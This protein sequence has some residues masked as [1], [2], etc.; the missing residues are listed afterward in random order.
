VGSRKGGDGQQQPAI[1]D[2]PAALVKKYRNQREA[3]WS[4]D[5]AR[6]FEDLCAPFEPGALREWADERRKEHRESH[7]TQ[8]LL[9]AATRFMGCLRVEARRAGKPFD[10]PDQL[11]REL[12]EAGCD[13]EMLITFLAAIAAERLELECPPRSK[14]RPGVRRDGTRPRLST[15]VERAL[16][17]YVQ[18]RTRRRRWKD[19]TA[20]IWL[21]EAVVAPG[22]RK[23]VL[24]ISQRDVEIVEKRIRAFPDAAFPLDVKNLATAYLKSL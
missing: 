8:R 13:R 24:R 17:D 23:P 14:R 12:C 15:R 10:W 21:V 9:R 6:T 3:I 20:L 11:L 22:G 5:D 19:V 2:S 18:G 7:S 4:D 1:R 16:S